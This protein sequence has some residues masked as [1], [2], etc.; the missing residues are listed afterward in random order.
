MA[1]RL[2]DDRLAEQIGELS[3]LAEPDQATGQVLGPGASAAELDAVSWLRARVRHRA[4]FGIAA[5]LRALS[6]AGRISPVARPERHN[7]EVLRDLPYLEDD[8]VWHRLDIYRP[9]DRPGPHPVVL[10]IHGGG[11]S[12]LSKESHWLMS[13]LFARAGYLVANINY[14]LAPRFPYPAAVLDSFAAFEWLCKNIEE[15][16][17][18]LSKLVLA[19]ESAGANLVTGL[20][21]ATCYERD[22][23]FSRRVYSLDVVPRAVLPACG[24]LQVSDPGRFSRKRPL[25]GWIDNILFDI[26]KMYLQ[27]D[28]AEPETWDLAD[29]LLVLER[30]ISPTRPLPAFFVTCGTRD[31]LLDDS[32]RLA[33]ALEKLG[34]PS[35]AC[36]YPKEIHAF[37]AM[38][39]RRQARS[40]WRKTFSF[41]RDV[42]AD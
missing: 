30:G 17:G 11:F 33:R 8:A 26:S 18:D 16:G 21:I 19:G 24:L 14:R 29:P 42:L 22:E 13:L 5:F 28:G 41:L 27:R 10:Y 12:T 2:S 23:P 1:D 15:L 20:A 36:Y 25:P 6:L 31:P 37:H 32:R 38:V 40:C 39:W 7:V 34:V 3:D 9:S 35:D 4:H